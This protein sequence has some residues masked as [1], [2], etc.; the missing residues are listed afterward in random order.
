MHWQ[1]RNTWH[2]GQCWW[3]PNPHQTV[4]HLITECRTMETRKRQAQ[5]LTQKCRSRVA[6]KSNT[7]VGCRVPETM[8]NDKAIWPLRDFL[9]AAEVLGGRDGATE[10]SEEWGNTMDREEKKSVTLNSPLRVLFFI[11][12]ST[13]ITKPELGGQKG[14]ERLRLS[15]IR[16]RTQDSRVRRS[17][18]SKSKRLKAKKS[19][20]MRWLRWEGHRREEVWYWRGVCSESG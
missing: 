7:A 6:L 3:S 13:S 16:S 12:F 14:S 18:N 20:R 1:G 15:I 8:G 5:K 10:R 4:E 9:K 17:Q 11:I 2:R 19:S